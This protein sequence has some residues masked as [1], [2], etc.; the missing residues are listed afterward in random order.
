MENIYKENRESRECK[1]L[2]DIFYT[3][4]SQK[5][6]LRKIED[7]E[8]LKSLCVSRE[9]VKE[10]IYVFKS[11]GDP[12]FLSNVVD[13]NAQQ[14]EKLNANERREVIE[15]ANILQN[16]LINLPVI[17]KLSEI[18]PGETG[19]FIYHTYTDFNIRNKSKSHFHIGWKEEKQMQEEQKEKKIG[20]F[21]QIL[22]ECNASEENFPHSLR[23]GGL[24]WI[25]NEDNTIYINL[26]GDSS[27]RGSYFPSIL[28]HFE[29]DIMNNFLNKKNSKGKNI[30]IRYN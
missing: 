19:I 13:S 12:F 30:A 21:D 3:L 6:G 18:S 15:Y 8:Y 11:M 14:F 20:M 17:H 27:I 28:K 22:Q 5:D 25:N 2:D 23:G 4:S 9:N 16:A 7:P 26:D 1:D 29:S 10:V 24:I